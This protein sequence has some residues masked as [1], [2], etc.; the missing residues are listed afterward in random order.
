VVR[1]ETV[2]GNV[3]T[4]ATPKLELARSVSGDVDISDIS[5]DRELTVSSVSGRL[6]GRNIKARSLDVSTV[7][8]DVSIVDAACDRVGG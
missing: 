4:S 2:S 8:G 6:R 3:N 5:T 1:A 7:S